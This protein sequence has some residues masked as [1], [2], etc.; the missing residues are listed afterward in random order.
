MTCVLRRE[1]VKYEVPLTNISAFYLAA[2]SFSLLSLLI[3]AEC[4]Q[5]ILLVTKS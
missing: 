1:G 5:Q 4:Q 2:L 3:C